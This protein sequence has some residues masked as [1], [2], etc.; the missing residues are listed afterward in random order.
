[1]ANLKDIKRRI[2]SVEK[3]QQITSAMRMVAAS[4]L[5]RAEAALKAARPYA[6][7][8]KQ[9][10]GELAAAGSDADAEVPF[11]DAD[12]G[13]DPGAEAVPQPLPDDDAKPVAAA[14]PTDAPALDVQKGR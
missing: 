3:T 12:T 11:E 5:R 1:M 13:A 6:T 10:L 14:D 8:M 9:T 7:R 4:K 2:G